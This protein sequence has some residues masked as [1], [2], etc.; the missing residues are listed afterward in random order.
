MHVMTPRRERRHLG[1]PFNP[2]T[3]MKLPTNC[4]EFVEGL[5]QSDETIR[6]WLSLSR[7]EGLDWPQTAEHLLLRTLHERQKLLEEL[8]PFR[9]HNVRMIP[10]L[11]MEQA[12]EYL[13]QDVSE[14]RPEQ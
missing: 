4:R 9:K 6:K 5:A 3:S 12:G 1:D 13:T 11:T 7:E 8:A 10:V 2:N 14:N